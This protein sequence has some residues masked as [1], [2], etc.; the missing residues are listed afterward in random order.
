V[1]ANPQV[2]PLVADIVA[3]NLDIE[4]RSQ[5]VERFKNL[6]PPEILAKEAGEPP[7]PKQPDPQAQMM[8]MQQ[9]LM[10]AQFEEK[11]KELEI[12]EA[13]LEIEK[14][15]NQLAQAELMIKAQKN[16]M[17]AELDIYNHKSDIK[18]AE[19]T[20]GLAGNKHE[21]DF[22]AKIASILSDLHKHENP[23]EKSSRE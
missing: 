1:Q 21:L 6:V 19:I 22:S 17:D 2:F 14:E 7:P 10:Q 20:H 23:Q 8:Q 13:K 18:H 3:D 11:K 9:Q 5:L 16:Q 4:K 15:K 12:K